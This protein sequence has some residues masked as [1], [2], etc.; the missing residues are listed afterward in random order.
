[1]NRKIRRA[2]LALA[3]T[4]TVLLSGCSSTDADDRGGISVVR[5][6]V[7]AEYRLTTA[8]QGD[9]TLTETVR[10]K[11]FAASQKNFGFG[12]SG[13]YYDDFL[14]SV[15]DTV[16]AG[17]MLGTLDCESLDQSIA[18]LETTIEELERSLE[19]N[20]SLL[21]LFDER[22]GDTPLSADDSAS[23]REYETA[24]RDAEDE[25]SIVSTELATLRTQREGRVVYADIDGT[26]TYVREVEN[27]ETSVN[28]RVVFTVTDL[29]SCA[30]S[31]TVEHPECLAEGEIYT[32]TISGEEYDVVLTTAEALGI[33]EEPMNE[34]SKLTRVY[35]S[36][37]TPSVN[38][39]ADDSG[40]FT[41]TIDRRE[42][43]VYVPTS[44]LTVVDGVTSV[45]VLDE[46]G[47]MSV[48]NVN[49]GLMTNRYAEITEGLEAGDEIV[50]Y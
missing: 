4:G 1:M 16:K 27:G 2:A 28:G 15:G 36:P 10:I 35:F 14:V 48:R 25:I 47:L 38:L 17:D 44:V 23:R 37:V 46:N 41:V 22:Q 20:R 18:A 50:Q 21:T 40:S 45:Y 29:D 13:V 19:R 34:Q 24:I 43:V 7:G 5:E 9:V 3:I 30:F 49:I 11:Y 31:S 33:E 26:V 32:A 8:R 42:D 6:D 12:E 39:S